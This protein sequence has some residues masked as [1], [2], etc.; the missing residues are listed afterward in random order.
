MKGKYFGLGTSSS[1]EYRALVHDLEANKIENKI[2]LLEEDKSFRVVIRG[3]SA[4]TSPT[5]IQNCFEAENFT[6]VKGTTMAKV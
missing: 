2:D 1:Y 6:N 5:L 3:L 4:C